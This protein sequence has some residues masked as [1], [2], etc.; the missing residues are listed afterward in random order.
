M[1]SNGFTLYGETKMLTHL[2]KSGAVYGKLHTADAGDGTMNASVHTTRQPVTFGD[3]D[4]NGV[5]ELAAPVTW[6]VLS[7]TEQLWGVSLWDASTAGHCV[8]IHEFA[9]PKNV[10]N[11]DNLKLSTL[12]VA[13]PVVGL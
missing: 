1:G 5:F 12:K 8:I 4:S 3:P 2:L 6:G 9:K 11:G 10:F 13:L 7:A